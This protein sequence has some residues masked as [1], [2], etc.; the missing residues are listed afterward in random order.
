M[1]NEYG[2]TY[3]G[4]MHENVSDAIT[5]EE[6][7]KCNA[8]LHYKSELSIDL[9]CENALESLTD[10]VKAK[11]MKWI[12]TEDYDKVIN[13]L[14]MSLGFL[15]PMPNWSKWTVELYVKIRPGF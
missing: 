4:S 9:P 14:D 7:T 8:R 2:I 3:Y 1:S 12:P 11:L 6:K 13:V 5:I 10:L 15:Q